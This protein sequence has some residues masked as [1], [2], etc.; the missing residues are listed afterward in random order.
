[1][2]MHCGIYFFGTNSNIQV[3]NI[4]V[5]ST[6]KSTERHFKSTFEFHLLRKTM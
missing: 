4:T 6:K 2:T 1:M 5:T 3:L